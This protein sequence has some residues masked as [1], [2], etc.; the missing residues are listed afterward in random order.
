[1]R[2]LTPLRINRPSILHIEQIGQIIRTEN[3][4]SMMNIRIITVSC[5]KKIKINSRGKTKSMIKFRQLHYTRQTAPVTGI[6]IFHIIIDYL[7]IIV[8]SNQYIASFQ[9]PP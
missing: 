9:Y 2:L 8:S 1:M 4:Y 5:S 7:I 3:S 6:R